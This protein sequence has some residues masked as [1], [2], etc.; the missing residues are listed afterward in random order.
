MENKKDAD[1]LGVESPKRERLKTEQII[2]EASKKKEV[3]V[4]A[5]HSAIG[6]LFPQRVN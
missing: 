1:M 6:P 5:I 4:Y 2:E 3:G